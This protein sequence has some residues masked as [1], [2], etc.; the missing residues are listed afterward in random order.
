M[1]AMGGKLTLAIVWRPLTITEHN[2]Y[3]S[4]ATSRKLTVYRRFAALFSFSCLS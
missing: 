2:A 1:A 4:T 3:V